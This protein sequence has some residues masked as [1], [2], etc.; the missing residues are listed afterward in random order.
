MF[1]ML[2]CNDKGIDLLLGLTERVYGMTKTRFAKKTSKKTKIPSIK[3]HIKNHSE[4]LDATK[5]YPKLSSLW[6]IQGSWQTI[7]N[8]MAALDWWR[9]F[10]SKEIYSSFEWLAKQPSPAVDWSGAV[11]GLNDCLA[12]DVLDHP[13][14]MASPELGFLPTETQMNKAMETFL[15]ADGQGAI[16][17]LRTR[18]LLQAL[19]GQNELLKE[20]LA[21]FDQ[22]NLSFEVESEKFIGKNKGRMDVAIAW[23]SFKPAKCDNLVVVEVKF[24]HTVKDGQLARYKNYARKRDMKCGLFLL[25]PQGK[26]DCKNRDWIGISWLTFL[27]RWER[28]LALESKMTNPTNKD[29]I[30]FRRMLWHRLF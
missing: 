17:R 21:S 12:L 25:T 22:T 5:I 28:L 29:F 13:L 30:R 14:K 26:S 11:L 4:Q 16:S 18:T 27:K 10:N 8:R 24:K 19:Y 7:K 23:P 3:K 6:P 20:M 2:S 9:D 1:S 15:L